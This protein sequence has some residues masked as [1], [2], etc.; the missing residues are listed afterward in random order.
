MSLSPARMMMLLILAMM[1]GMMISPMQLEM[2]EPGPESGIV[3]KEQPGLLITNCRIHSQKVFVRFNPGLIYEKNLRTVKMTSWA[4]VRWTREIITHA[5]VDITH[6]LQQLQKF[7]ITQAELSGVNRREKRF[8]GGL[9]TAAAALGSL[10]SLGVSSVNAVNVASIKRHMNELQNEIPLIQ[11]QLDLQ[12]GQI[13]TVGRTVEGTVVVL[14]SHSEALMKTTAAVDML[15]SV[16]QV[17]YAHTQLATMLMSDLIR[18]ISSSIDTLAMG[19]IPPYLVSLALVQELLST[20]TRDHITPMQAHLA[21]TLGS[22]VPIY[23]NPEARELAFLINLPVITPDNIYRLKDVVNVGIWQGETHVKVHTPS[24][25]AYHDSTPDLY[26]APN[27]RMCT[28]TRDIHYLC[29][30]K[31]FIRDD[32]GGLCGLKIL[33]K[34]SQCPTT[35]TPSYQIIS[36]HAEI[37]GSRW[38]VNTPAKVATINYDQHDTSSKIELPHRTLW[39]TV[40]EGAILHVGDVALYHLNPEQYE[41]EIEISDFFVKH[42]IELDKN[43]LIQI[44]YEGSKT[45]DVSPVE[46]VLKEIANH[47]R[48][49]IQTLSYAWSTADTVIAALVALGYVLTFGVTYF[50]VRRTKTLRGKLDKCTERLHR[51]CRRRRVDQPANAT[52]LVDFDVETETG[53][54]DNQYSPDVL[55]LGHI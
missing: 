28:L 18:D 2:V 47:D 45:I 14:N 55:E 41:T 9:L 44:Q 54:D 27:L 3:L 36:T 33:N 10:F 13:A 25:V 51:V 52:D 7:T 26:L 49:P 1:L 15:L 34:D 43:T 4:G 53:I 39:I 23:V 16:L 48:I 22:S 40:P 20:N 24:V 31:P 30:S 6:M 29:P 12:M 37:V 50:Y 5:E 11:K 35:L 17:D 46:N 21:Y 19:R 32:T 42:S 8:I 38:L